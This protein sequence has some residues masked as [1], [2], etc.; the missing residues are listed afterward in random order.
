[1]TLNVEAYPKKRLNS[2]IVL[3]EPT[4]LFIRTSSLWGS[5]CTANIYLE[6][7]PNADAVVN[8]GI[9]KAP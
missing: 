7:P 5:G 3:I 2:D 8:T 6:T 9:K 4:V 1:M